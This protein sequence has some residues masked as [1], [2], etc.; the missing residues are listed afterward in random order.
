MTGR[1]GL[2]QAEQRASDGKIN[3]FFKIVYCRHTTDVLNWFY[4][5]VARE[6]EGVSRRVTR[7]QR[8]GAPADGL[9]AG[10]GARHDGASGAYVHIGA[11][12]RQLCKHLNK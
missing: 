10:P 7:S 9:D 2:P 5:L 8:G 1:L 3:E 4:T 6:A 12:A 11:M